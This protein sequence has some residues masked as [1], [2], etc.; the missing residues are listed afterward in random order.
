MTLIFT[1]A[2][3][4]KVVQVSDRRLTW[5]DGRL[6][7]DESNKAICVSCKDADFSVAYTGLAKIGKKLIA[8]DDWLTD[9]LTSIDA[10]GKNLIFISKSLD[11]TLPTILDETP[12]HERIKDLTFV[13]AG[14]WDGYPFMMSISNKNMSKIYMMKPDTSPKNATAILIHGWE[15]AVDRNIHQH[16][17]KLKRKRFF[18]SADGEDVAEKLVFLIR[19]STRTPQAKNRVGRNCMSVV[20]TLK[21][22]LPKNCNI[23]AKYHPDK[24]S[25]IGYSPHFITYLG[26]YSHMEFSH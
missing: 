12:V 8:S 1:L 11:R 19:A 18:Q 26:T 17:K 16:I 21:P 6:D 20:I 13:F 14:Y 7:D 24:E 23:R 9:Y 10:A 25:P 5:P 22:D 15:Q 4:S 3:Y 2:T